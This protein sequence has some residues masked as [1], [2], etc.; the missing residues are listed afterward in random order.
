MNRMFSPSDLGRT[1]KPFVFLDFLHG[2]VKRDGLNFGFHPHSGIATLTY[3]LNAA[4][5]YTDTEGVDGTLEPGGLEWMK[6]GGG[7]WHKSSFRGP[8]SDMV[9]FQFW[10]A[11]PAEIED[12]PSESLYI[13]PRQVPKKGNYK[14]LVGEYGGLRSPVPCPLDVNVIEVIFERSGDEFVYTYPAGHST[15]YAFVHSGS[16]FV[17]DAENESSDNEIFVLDVYGEMLTVKATQDKTRVI[18]ASGVPHAHSL[19]LGMYSVHTSPESL[20]RGEAKIEKIGDQMKRDG[21]M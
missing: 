4:V 11:L 12:G 18:I 5:H 9:A 1:L 20:A 16:A 10:F 13:T 21:K 19:S 6:A 17:G 2:D 15:S 14:V 8:I 7:A 3:S